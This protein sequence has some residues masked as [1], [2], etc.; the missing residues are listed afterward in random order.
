MQPSGSFLRD[1]SGA[2]RSLLASGLAAQL[3]A[4]KPGEVLS[5]PAGDGEAAVV[6]RLKAVT[7]ADPAD[8]TTRDRLAA[9]LAA[10]YADDLSLLYRQ[11]LEKEQGVQINRANMDNTN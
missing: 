6:A 1:G 11:A 5:G 9:N 4:L 7:P 10:G 3:F 2:D 8:T